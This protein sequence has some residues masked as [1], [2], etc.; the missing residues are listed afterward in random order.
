MQE[1]HFNRRLA[2]R[3]LMA[4][5]ARRA[6]M[7]A[8]Q[9]GYA[10]LSAAKYGIPSAF[11]YG[12]YKAPT[13]VK[14]KYKRVFKK[15]SIQR[16]NKRRISYLKKRLD[17]N[18]ATITHRSRTSD[19]A[20]VAGFNQCLYQNQ[21]GSQKSAI[22]TAISVLKFFDP[23]TPATLQDVNY[24]NGTFQKQIL[25]KNSSKIH[26]KNNYSVPVKLELWI[27]R[28]KAD[29]SQ[30]P[31]SAIT[32]GFADIGAIAINDP[33]SRPLDSYILRDLWTLKRKKNVILQPG[34]SCM[35]SHS[36]KPFSFDT[37]L[38]DTH[39]LDYIKQ[40]KAN[41]WLYRV[42]G[43][44]AHDS[45]EDQQGLQRAGVDLYLDKTFVVKYDAGIDLNFI[46][47]SNGTDGF[48]NVP[49]TTVLDNTQKQFNL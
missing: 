49:N 46:I 45:I 18:E 32:A 35:A 20:I 22:E 5:M 39:N 15:K 31:A 2:R 17:N 19:A 21:A 10:G 27:C 26:F 1:P 28:P 40:F 43:V 33:L 11:A 29:T 47:T 37:S 44:L 30:S 25:I 9:L 14:S 42:E 7:L 36:E 24:N 23:A 12:A 16:Q 3:G 48:T 34:Q 6:R 8:V 4:S 41:S 38:V 13:Y